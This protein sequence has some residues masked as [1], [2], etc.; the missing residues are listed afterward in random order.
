MTLPPYR[1]LF[2]PPKDDTPSDDALER[3]RVQLQAALDGD[4]TVEVVSAVDDWNKHF[5]RCGGW[6]GWARDVGAGYLYGTQEPRFHALV[7]VSR[8]QRIGRATEGI[9]H[10]AVG[11]RRRLLWWNKGQFYRI[12]GVR[13]DSDSW[14]EGASLALA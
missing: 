7:I 11:A 12:V 13:R 10:A 14:R 2:C 6:E 4:R 5:A 8:S 3:L 9:V 1:V